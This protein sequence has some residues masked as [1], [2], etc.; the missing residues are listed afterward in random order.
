M[1]VYGIVYDFGDGSAGIRWYNKEDVDYV[2]SD[3]YK[4]WEDVQVNE[5]SPAAVIDIPEG[6]NPE[7][8]GIRMT[9]VDRSG[10]D[11]EDEDEDV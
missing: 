8:L 5:G 2:L 3:D 6:F 10:E 9:V 11:D 1:K 7:D 4:Y